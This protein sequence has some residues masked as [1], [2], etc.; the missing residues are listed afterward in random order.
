MTQDEKTGRNRI[1]NDN[2]TFLRESLPKKFEKIKKKEHKLKKV[3]SF[4]S[5]NLTVISS[6]MTRTGV[7]EP[8]YL[9][10]DQN[11][12]IYTQIER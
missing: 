6:L 5:K 8:G 10:N 7:Q 4:N 3:L 9:N 1:T 12:D 11:F 2:L